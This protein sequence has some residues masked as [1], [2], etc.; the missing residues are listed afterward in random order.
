[1]SRGVELVGALTPRFDTKALYE[2]LDRRRAEQG[3]TWQDVAR[4][5]GVS[6]ATLTRTRAGGRL[7]VDG[8]LAMVAWL[9]VPV[10]HFVRQAPR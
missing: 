5:T 6:T 7:E 10:E 8:M 9:G 2:A 3:L 4:A 1:M